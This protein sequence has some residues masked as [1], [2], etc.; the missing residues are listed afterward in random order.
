MNISELIRLSLE[1]DIFQGDI[2]TES[3]KL[4]NKEISAKLVAKAEG[5]L[6]GLDVFCETFYQVDDQVRIDRYKEDSEKLQ[7]GDVICRIYGASASLLKAERVALNFLQR[8]SGIAT[9][10]AELVAKIGD[11][12]AKLLD[13]RKTTPL[14]RQL[15]KYAVRAGGGFNHR[16]GL[17]DMLMLKEN[18][19]LAAGSISRAVELVRQTDSSHKLEVEVTNLEE[20]QEAVS[21]GVDRV[22]L[23]NMSISEMETAV[24]KFHGKVELEA[25]GN[26]NLSS[27]SQIAKTGVDF[28]SSGLMTHSYK[29]MD[30]SLI[31][32]EG[33]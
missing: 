12:R 18:H 31:F 33:K 25:S 17:Y 29:S 19:I 16:F 13:T 32:E 14:L 9:L 22:M 23:D 1:E 28:I 27:I 15:E 24:L 6:A 21:C 8:M 2:T 20:L 7:K 30:I 3:L 11:E 4:G 5:V 10:T 26:V